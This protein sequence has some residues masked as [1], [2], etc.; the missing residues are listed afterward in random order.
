MK[1][2]DVKDDTAITTDQIAAYM[3]DLI[4]KG[5]YPGGTVMMGLKDKTEVVF[6]GTKSLLR[7]P[8][9]ETIGDIGPAKEIV[10]RERG[11]GS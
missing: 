6:E 1:D 7:G 10:D 5:E 9:G 4:Q 11:K 8:N 3:A 2:F